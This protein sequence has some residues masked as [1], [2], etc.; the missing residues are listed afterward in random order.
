MMHDMRNTPNRTHAQQLVTLR[1]G[2]EVADLLRDLYVSQGLSQEAIAR[3][4]GV[5]R[6]TVA[7]WLREYGI[8]PAD[9]QA[10]A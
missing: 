1:T 7:M 8:S 4:L 5:T 6:N 2:R 9:R 10:I 3:H